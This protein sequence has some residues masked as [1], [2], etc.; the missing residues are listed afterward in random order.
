MAEHR[1]PCVLSFYLGLP[2]VAG[3]KET[4]W[5]FTTNMTQELELVAGS[6]K[7]KGVE[8]KYM[9]CF[10]RSVL[11]LKLMLLQSQLVPAN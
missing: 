10:N 5:C 3:G 9:H 1:A 7:K 2:S 11:F 8:E 6:K 4:D